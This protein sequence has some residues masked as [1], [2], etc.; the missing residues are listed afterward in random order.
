MKLCP[1]HSGIGYQVC[2]APFHKGERTPENALLLMRSR[3][4]A[5]ALNLSDYIIQTTHPDHP[6]F[7]V[8]RDEWV[9]SIQSFCKSTRFLGL[10]ILEFEEGLER[11]TVSFHATLQSQNNDTSFSEKSLFLR[12]DGCWLY[13][14]ALAFKPTRSS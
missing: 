12:K 1:C 6:L 8:S 4:A 11:N 9:K 10:D 3:Y 13:R 14:D 7:N 5:Y 2:C